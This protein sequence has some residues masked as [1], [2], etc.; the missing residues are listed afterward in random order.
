MH[1]KYATFINACGIIDSSTATQ[2]FA[3]VTT[4]SIWFPE[5]FLWHQ[6]FVKIV[7]LSLSNKWF[8][9][10][11]RNSK[12]IKRN[13]S[14]DYISTSYIQ[15]ILILMFPGAD[16]WPVYDL[17]GV[18][19]K[20]EIHVQWKVCNNIITVTDLRTRS[21]PVLSLFANHFN[22]SCECI[23]VLSL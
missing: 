2:Y 8:V 13:I 7:F 1:R 9:L 18:E 16:N 20:V 15:C 14:I 5:I 6:H 4:A 11:F 12:M 17:L 10:P 21:V 22:L 19:A 23:V 3:L